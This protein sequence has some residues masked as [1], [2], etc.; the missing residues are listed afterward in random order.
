MSYTHRFVFADS[1]LVME[2]SSMSHKIA[3]RTPVL[4]LES[5]TDHLID[6]YAYA[7]SPEILKAVPAEYGMI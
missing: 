1:C 4:T 5:I 7:L 2:C 6:K 3:L